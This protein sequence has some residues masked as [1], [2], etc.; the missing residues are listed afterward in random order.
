MSIEDVWWLSR[1]CLDE[2]WMVSG[3]YLSKL[4]YCQESNYV[5]TRAKRLICTMMIS[6]H[7]FS[8]YPLLSA[9]DVT[10]GDGGGGGGYLV[11]VSWLEDV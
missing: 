2:V 5:R 4:S 3:W 7:H 10:G 1:E 11:S 8:L 9:E 6:H